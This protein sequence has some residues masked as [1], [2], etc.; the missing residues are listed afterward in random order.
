MGTVLKDLFLSKEKSLHQWKITTIQ[1]QFDKVSKAL[2]Y[3]V[4]YIVLNCLSN[5]S[6]NR[7]QTKILNHRQRVYQLELYYSL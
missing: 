3:I 1:Y 7:F 2:H 4:L 5:M 6:K